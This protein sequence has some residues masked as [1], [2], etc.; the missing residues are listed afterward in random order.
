MERH[1]ECPDDPK[2]AKWC[3]EEPCRTA[4]TIA[5]L[6]A[7]RDEI[8][9]LT[10]LVDVQCM[11]SAPNN[12]RST[13]KDDWAEYVKETGDDTLR[14]EDAFMH[15]FADG[16]AACFFAKR[17]ER[18]SVGPADT[19]RPLNVEISGIDNG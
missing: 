6:R 18:V 7:Q 19:R 15:G 12:A 4:W 9:R 3:A 13:W 11:K 1:H 10:D 17:E 16:Y 2:R 5:T 14:V 8:A